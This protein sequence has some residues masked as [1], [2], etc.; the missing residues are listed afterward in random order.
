MAGVPSTMRAVLPTGHGGP[1][2]LEY[3]EDCPVPE[4]AAGDVL[5]EVTACGVSNTDI[6]VREGACG[7]ED[8]PRA[9]SSWRRG[10]PIRFPRIQGADFVGRL[11]VTTGRSR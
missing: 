2:V 1:E 11:V 7:T 3:R 4:P 10:V 8:D 6:R 5:V 9:V